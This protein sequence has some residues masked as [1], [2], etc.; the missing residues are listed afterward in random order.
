MD[1][2]DKSLSAFLQGKSPHTLELFN[3]FVFCYQKIGDV[4]LHAA[5][6]M[7]T[8][9]SRINFAYIIQFGKNFID[10]VFP[11]KHPYEDNMCFQKIKLVPG[12]SDYNHHLR[13]YYKEDI[14][15]EVLMYMSM[16][17]KNGN[18]KLC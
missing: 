5:K 9:S 12:S 7:I 17:Y 14:N 6:T 11:F 15:D 1:Y 16:A 4:K 8:F 3:H 2:N 13:I 18:V 10:V